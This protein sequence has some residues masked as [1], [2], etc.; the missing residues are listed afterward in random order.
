VIVSH[1]LFYP[2]LVVACHLC[3]GDEATRWRQK[4]YF[5]IDRFQDPEKENHFNH[6]D[7]PANGKNLSWPEQLARSKAARSVSTEKRRLSFEDSPDSGDPDRPLAETAEPPAKKAI[8]LPILGKHH[9]VKL[10]LGRK[11][12]GQIFIL[13]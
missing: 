7:Q 9:K 2:Y 3:G 8:I 12:I 10:P 1:I 4:N 13:D 11:V 5:V 6:R